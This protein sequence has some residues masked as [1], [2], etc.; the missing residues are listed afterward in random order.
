MGDLL[1][2]FSRLP[3]AITDL[4]QKSAGGVADLCVF[5]PS[6]AWTVSANTL[7]S[8]GK[9]TPFSGYELPGRVRWSVVGGLVAF[10]G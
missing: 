1:Q 5:D 8:Q 10:E 6:V 3:A 2:D 4:T 9:H 7:R